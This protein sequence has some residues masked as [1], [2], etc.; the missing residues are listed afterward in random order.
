MYLGLVHAELEDWANQ[1]C[2]YQPEFC[3]MAFAAAEQAWEWYDEQVN[4]W[5]ERQGCGSV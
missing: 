3:N 5:L 4:A 2:E 1:V